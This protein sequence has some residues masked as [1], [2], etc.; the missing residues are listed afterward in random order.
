MI[1]HVAVTFVSMATPNMTRTCLNDIQKYQ[2]MTYS[3]QPTCG[4]PSFY[5]LFAES[6]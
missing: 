1:G 2:E 3:R 6:M 5:D 4:I